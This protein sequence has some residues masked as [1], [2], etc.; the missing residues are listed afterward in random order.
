MEFRF[1]PLLDADLPSM[2][3]WLND[4]D[5]VRWWEGDDVSWAGIVRDY[6]P[7]REP[8]PVDHFVVALDGEDIGWISC[9]AIADWAEEVAAWIQH[10]VDP[11]AGT[12]DYLVGDSARR[13]R[14]VGT[15]IIEQFVR[16]I[17]FGV[18]PT[19]PQIAVAPMDANVASWRALERAGFH[20]L[21]IVPDVLGATRLMV[22]D[23]PI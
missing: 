18:H 20:F 8:E 23:R 7:N 11:A 14:G 19:W 10:G 17:G 5:V 16:E 13:G 15:V 21:A 9:S 12:I 6:S 3:R 4:P 22:I 2:H 1:R